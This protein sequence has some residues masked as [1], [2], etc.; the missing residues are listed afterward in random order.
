MGLGG[1]IGSCWS[2]GW[3]GVARLGRQTYQEETFIVELPVRRWLVLKT[4]LSPGSVV[5]AGDADQAN[6]EDVAGQMGERAFA[7]SP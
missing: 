2:A 3:S 5:P 1:G 6:K 7:A 4:L